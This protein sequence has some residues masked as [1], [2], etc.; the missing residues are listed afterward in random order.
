MSNGKGI[1]ITGLI[2]GIIGLGLGGYVFFNNTLAPLFGLKTPPTAEPQQEIENYYS[3]NGSYLPPSTSV[4]NNIKSISIEFSVLKNAS[5]YV[6]Y[7]SYILT[8]NP[9]TI[10]TFLYVNGIK[11]GVLGIKLTVDSTSTIRSPLALQYY[12][13]TINPGTYNISIWVETNDPITTL[14]ENSLYVQ[15]ITK[16]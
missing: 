13:K 5:L 16:N 11:K 1:A 10:E 12:N 4:L 3:F 6:L 8:T 2:F 15:T 9:D 14:Y 7:N